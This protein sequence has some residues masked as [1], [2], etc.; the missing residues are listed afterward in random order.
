MRAPLLLPP[1]PVVLSLLILGSGEDIPPLICPALLPLRAKAV[2]LEFCGNFSRQLC[3]AGGVHGSS[4]P[5]VTP[6]EEKKSRQ[7]FQLVQGRK[8]VPEKPLLLL[9][10][11]WRKP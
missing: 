6:W 7:V 9:Q 3:P 8:R 1:A 10:F 11:S 5:R 4:L 2:P